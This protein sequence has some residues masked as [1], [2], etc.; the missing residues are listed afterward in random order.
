MKDLKY[1]AYSAHDTTLAALMC[2]LDA[3][4]KILINGGYPKYSAAMFFE[5]WNTTNG[6]G[7][8]VYYHRDFTED[9]LED[10]TDLL[11]HCSEHMD[12]NGFCNYEKFR[13]NGIVY[14][15]GNEDELCQDTKSKRTS[16][17]PDEYETKATSTVTLAPVAYILLLLQVFIS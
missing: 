6:P 2:T 15:P 12:S 3:K 5:L 17:N 7:L 10:V 11:D 13:T 16:F 14:Y 4:H 1:Y 8:K 9:Q